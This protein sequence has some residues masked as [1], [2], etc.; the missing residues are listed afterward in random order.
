MQERLIS[1]SAKKT[2]T[3]AMIYMDHGYG[4]Y[5]TSCQ[6]QY[7]VMG[8]DPLKGLDQTLNILYWGLTPLE[9]K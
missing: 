9:K 5:G 7:F 8:S 4:V 3:E 2:V 1:A 6:V